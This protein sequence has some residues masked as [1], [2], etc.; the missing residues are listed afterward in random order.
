MDPGKN[1]EYVQFTTIRKLGSHFSNFVHT[2]PEG[3]FASFIANEGAGLSMT[4]SSMKNYLQKL[5][6]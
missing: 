3:I 1:A 5:Q 6:Q 2:V 4:N